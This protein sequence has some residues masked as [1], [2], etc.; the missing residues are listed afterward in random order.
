[1]TFHPKTVDQVR[2]IWG[3]AKEL[4]L[5]PEEL[6]S[7]VKKVWP[8]TGGHI[9]TLS[10][11]EATEI[12]KLLKKRAGQPFSKYWKIKSKKKRNASCRAMD[13]Q[14]R[15]KAYL[16]AREIT[17]ARHRGEKEGTESSDAW[18]LLHKLARHMDV[19]YFHRC[20]AKQASAIIEA[21]KSI[22]KKTLTN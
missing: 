5:S 20:T 19:Q 6:R 4:D 10:S 11:R 18:D 3:L 22:R 1:M 7:F 15:D 17:R 16:I 12:I 2:C 14:Q 9:S 21:L 13:N 8:E